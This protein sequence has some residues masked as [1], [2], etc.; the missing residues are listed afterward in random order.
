MGA[1]IQ[2]PGRKKQGA[3]PLDPVAAWAGL[4]ARQQEG[5]VAY[6]EAI[7]LLEGLVEREVLGGA[8]DVPRPD[9]RPLG[10]HACTGCGC[11]DD[12]ACE[13]GCSWAAPELCSCC[14]RQG[15]PTRL[16]GR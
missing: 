8:A 5:I 10:V 13:G 11:T 16:E 7:Q 6:A 3:A 4:S 14:A 1:L 2:L 15:A 12:H 9:L